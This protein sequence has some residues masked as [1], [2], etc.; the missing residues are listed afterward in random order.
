MANAYIV[1]SPNILVYQMFVG[2]AGRIAYSLIPLICDGSVFGKQ[3]RILLRLI[4]IEMSM[5]KLEGIHHSLHK[6][7][8]LFCMQATYDMKCVYRLSQGQI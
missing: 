7:V 6:T 2:A 8:S 4:D 1:T 3:R 5:T